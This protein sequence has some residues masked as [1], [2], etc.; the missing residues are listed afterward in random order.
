MIATMAYDE[1]L[2]S[3]IRELIASEDGFTEQKMFGGIGYLIDGNMAVGVS[4]EGGLMIHCPKEETEALLAKPGARPFEMR[5]REMKGWL[6]VDAESV[7]TERELESWV[8]ESVAFARALPP[9][10]K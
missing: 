8:M 7:S 2:A 6:R 10:K 9:K 3:R 1:D 4:G 5:G